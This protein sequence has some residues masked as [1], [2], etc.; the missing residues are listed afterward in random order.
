[1]MN[2]THVC[3]DD[4][5]TGTIEMDIPGM[6]IRRMKSVSQEY[7]PVPSDPTQQPQESSFSVLDEAEPPL[8]PGLLSAGEFE[9]FVAPLTAPPST[10]PPVIVTVA[11]SPEI[12][13]EV[14]VVEAED[15]EADALVESDFAAESAGLEAPAEDPEAGAEPEAVD[16]QSPQEPPATPG[17]LNLPRPPSAG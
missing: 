12:V 4:D 13:E 8:A 17:R 3:E 1:M 7:E 5:K 14:M 10:A 11:P 9:N 16:E 6:Y 15:L 2:K